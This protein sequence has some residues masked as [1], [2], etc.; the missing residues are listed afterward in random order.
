MVLDI[1]VIHMAN[2]E[3]NGRNFEVVIYTQTFQEQNE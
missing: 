1:L 3:K 2:F